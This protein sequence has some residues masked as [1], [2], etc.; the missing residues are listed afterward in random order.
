MYKTRHDL[1]EETRQRII[2][3]MNSRL[4]DAIDLKTQTKHAHWNVKGPSFIALHELFDQIA[5]SVE[6]YSDLIA[7]RVVQLGGKAAGTARLVARRS[8]LKEYPLETSDGSEHVEALS[9]ALSAFGNACRRAIDS[10]GELGDADA[11][12]IFTEISRGIDK[13]LWFV[14]AH[15]QT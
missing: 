10:A 5:S 4:A 9:N 3:L 15:Q 7:E 6:E 12:D 11:A 14:E 8:S 1:P 2:E 13:Y